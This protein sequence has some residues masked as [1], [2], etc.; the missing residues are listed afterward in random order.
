MIRLCGAALLASLLAGCQGTAGDPDGGTRA[1]AGPLFDAGPPPIKYDHYT[2]RTDGWPTGAR[3]RGAAVL[4]NVL[5]VASDQGVLSLDATET[6]WK[7]VTT[8][9]TG[10]VKPTS[11]IR[12]D[13]SLVMTAAGAAGGGL[14]VKQFDGD[15]AQ[16]TAAPTTPS[17]MVVKKSTDYLLAT[18][19]GLFAATALSGPWVRRSV[20]NT[21]VFATPLTQLVAAPAQQKLFAHG[22]TG[23]LFE[24]IDTGRTWTASVPRGTVDALT[25]DRAI[26]VVS[27]SMDA[28]QRSDNYGN[29]FRAA[30]N[31]IGDGV[32]LYV[33]E[34]TRF[35][36][37]GAGGLKSSDD[38]GVTFTDNSDGL[39]VATAVRA[40]FFAGS[41][42]IVDTADG[43]WINQP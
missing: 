15:W 1:D 37:A 28:Q 31:P 26:V 25:A 32:V 23:G 18:T 11:L 8:P 5:F 17:W 14:Y 41:Y 35:W 7:P 39:P 38:D 43:P 9:L 4:S 12:V 22:A 42:A 21:A 36:A 40:L 29:T 30:A 13:Q 19:G 10:D 24:S 2:Q 3:V 20:V 16:V 27:T 34:G 33:S 6:R